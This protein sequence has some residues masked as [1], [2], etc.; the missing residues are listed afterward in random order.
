M[1]QTRI[2]S[3]LAAMD[4]SVVI[5]EVLLIFIILHPTQG[6]WAGPKTNII[7]IFYAPP[8]TT[9]TAQF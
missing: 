3:L 5:V 9:W 7:W 1:M 8:W 6:P 4:R 2:Q